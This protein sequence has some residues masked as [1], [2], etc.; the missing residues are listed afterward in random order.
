MRKNFQRLVSFFVCIE[1]QFL[2]GRM[3]DEGEEVDQ[4][5]YEAVKWFRKSAQQ[6]YAGAQ[7]N[8][9]QLGETW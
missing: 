8:L 4:D 6:G 1:A 9:R 7:S 5:S 3:Y 2:L